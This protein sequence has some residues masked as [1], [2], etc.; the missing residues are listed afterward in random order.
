M[1]ISNVL[2]FSLTI[3]YIKVVFYWDQQ[4]LVGWVGWVF[5]VLLGKN[6]FWLAWLI[7]LFNRPQTR[8]KWLKIYLLD[9]VA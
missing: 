5:C 1:Q 8:L 7:N 4:F 3:S 2:Y 6:P 9:Y